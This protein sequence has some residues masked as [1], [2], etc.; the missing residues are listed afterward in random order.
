MLKEQ[1]LITLFSTALSCRTSVFFFFLSSIGGGLPQL[2]RVSILLTPMM[3]LVER[4]S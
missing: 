4:K 3:L 2:F 1:A